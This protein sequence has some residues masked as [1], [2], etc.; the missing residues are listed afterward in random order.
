MIMVGTLNADQRKLLAN[1]FSNIAVGWFGAGVISPFLVRTQ[2][3]FDIYTHV[4]WGL[5]MAYVFL[6]ISLY[7]ME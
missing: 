5:F 2:S 6:R 3:S 4:V 7:L 1:F